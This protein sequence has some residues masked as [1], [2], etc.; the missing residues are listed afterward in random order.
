MSVVEKPYEIDHVP[1]R[2]HRD[3]DGRVPPAKTGKTDKEKE[4][5]FLSRALAAFAVHRLTGCGLDEAAASLVDGGGDAGIDAVHHSPTSNTLYV[6]QSKF[7]EVGRGEPDLGDVS[8]FRD[9]VD[10]R[11]ART[12]CDARR[13]S[14]G[15]TG[16]PS[17][18]WS[19]HFPLL[20]SRGAL[21]PYRPSRMSC[22]SRTRAS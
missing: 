3:F 10:I 12:R 1:P 20:R 21:A 16:F 6:V 17:L 19:S 15:S 13:T 11:S 14:G 8:K 22:E 4:N 2:L 18:S 9:G 7:I 5:N